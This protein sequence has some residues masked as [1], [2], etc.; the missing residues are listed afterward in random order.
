MPKGGSDWRDWMDRVRQW[1]GPGAVRALGSGCPL[2]RRLAKV[3]ARS[4]CDTDA[5]LGGLGRV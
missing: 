4:C 1:V 5:G 3:V 2:V